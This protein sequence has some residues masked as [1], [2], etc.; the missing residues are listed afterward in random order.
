MDREPVEHAPEV[1]RGEF[2]GHYIEHNKPPIPVTVRVEWAD[3]GE[4]D[5]DGWTSQWTRTH[6]YVVRNLEPGGRL[7][8]FWARAGDVRRRE[9]DT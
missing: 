1:W 3:G 2:N 9:T 7:R 8:P 4:G 5:L 6:V